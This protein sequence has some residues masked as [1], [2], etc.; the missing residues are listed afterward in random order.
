MEY[1]KSAVVSAT[2]GRSLKMKNEDFD[3]LIASIKEAGKIKRGEAEASRIHE[4]S[5]PNIKVIR[6]AI[7][8]QHE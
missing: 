2:D 1:A 5:E 3:E 7:T 8:R 6:E 4:F